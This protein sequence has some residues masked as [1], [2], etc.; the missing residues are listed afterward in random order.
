MI[1]FFKIIFFRWV[2]I[3]NQ[4]GLEASFVAM[5]ILPRSAVQSLARLS[6]NRTHTS[7]TDLKW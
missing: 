2:E 1:P 5:E 4:T 6:W 3:T 7:Q